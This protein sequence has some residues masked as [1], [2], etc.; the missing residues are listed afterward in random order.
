MNEDSTNDSMMIN[1]CDE[2]ENYLIEVRRIKNNEACKDSHQNVCI[3]F[4]I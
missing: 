4:V 1:W 2:D 3:F